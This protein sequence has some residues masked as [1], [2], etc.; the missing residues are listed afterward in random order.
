MRENIQHLII[1]EQG[2]QTHDVLDLE[3]EQ[4][5]L[6]LFKVLLRPLWLK[7]LQCFG[8]TKI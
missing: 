1:P 3:V 7:T 5:D 8:T 4:V 6:Q 2:L